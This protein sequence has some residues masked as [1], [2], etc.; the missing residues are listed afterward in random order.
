MLFGCVEVYV[1]LVLVFRKKTVIAP[2]VER[3]L[4]AFLQA[5]SRERLCPIKRINGT[6]DHVHVLIKLP[7]R[8]A[9]DDLVKLLKNSTIA[10]LNVH[11]HPDFGWQEGYG[12]FSCSLCHLQPLSDYISNQ[13]EHHRSLT[14]A[15]EM[16]TLTKAW[17]IK[18]VFEEP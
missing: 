12:A 10:W 3:G 17:G 16:S 15:H 4:Y 9:L 2:S 8:L 13:K 11:D 5:Y 7:A 18:W 14:F 1:H 6:D